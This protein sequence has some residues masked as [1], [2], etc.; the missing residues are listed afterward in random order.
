MVNARLAEVSDS[1]E[2]SLKS[3]AIGCF[4]T[5]LL[6]KYPFLAI[7]LAAWEGYQSNRTS[8]FI[9]ELDEKIA[10]IEFR[11]ID[12]EYIKSEE[13]FDLIQ[14][15]LK[16]RMQ[17]R[18]KEKAKFIVNL[19]SESMSIDRDR[20]F[21]TDIKEAFLLMIDGMS[22]EELVF[23][24]DFAQDKYKGKSRDNIYQEGDGQSIAM[25]AL[26]AKGILR[27]EDTW[28]KHLTVSMLG[29]EFIEYVKI[30]GRQV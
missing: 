1:V 29:R 2:R 28:E 11:K 8:E 9:K 3:V 22:N 16:I 27:D 4:K 13:F 26:Y 19:L 10:E 7:P 12:E 15:G 17:H 5:V 24:R 25:D 14:R 30:L 6:L 21:S 23:L 20:R 18:S